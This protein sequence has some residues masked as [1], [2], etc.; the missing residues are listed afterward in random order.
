VDS[1]GPSVLAGGPG[2]LSLLAADF[3]FAGNRPSWFDW[4]EK[5]CWG[6]AKTMVVKYGP[7]GELE[8]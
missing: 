4:K 8:L 2:L 7:V 6:L 3:M 5:F 1:G